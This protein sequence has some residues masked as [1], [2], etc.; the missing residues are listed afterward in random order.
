MSAKWSIGDRVV[1]I[2]DH[3]TGRESL[4]GCVGTVEHPSSES[5]YSPCG[6][7]CCVLIDGRPGMIYPGWWF[8]D[9]FLRAESSA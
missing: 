1:V 2:E 6:S 7:E 3:G 9:S 8:P 5:K 4:V